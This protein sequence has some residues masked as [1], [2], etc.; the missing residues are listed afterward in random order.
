[1]QEWSGGRQGRRL[2]KSPALGREEV[3]AAARLTPTS[4]RLKHGSVWPA[5]PFAECSSY[6]KHILDI[7]IR[8]CSEAPVIVTSQATYR[9]SSN[10]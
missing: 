9:H 3:S 7:L 8:P 1:M 4:G 5:P 10:T 2:T 6:G